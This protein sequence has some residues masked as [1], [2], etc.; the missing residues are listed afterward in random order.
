MRKLKHCLCLFLSAGVLGGFLP[1]GAAEDPEESYF[2]ENTWEQI[3]QAFLQDWGADPEKVAVG[4]RN[5][6]TGEEHFLQGDTYIPAAQHV[7]SGPE[8]VLG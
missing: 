6:V 5:T 3:T 7:Q 8:H 1:A 2:A 4:Y